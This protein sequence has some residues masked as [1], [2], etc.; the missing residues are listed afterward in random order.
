MYDVARRRW[1]QSWTIVHRAVCIAVLVLTARPLFAQDPPP[2]IGPFVIDFHGV[3]PKFGDDPQLAAS[4][5]LSQTELPGPTIGLSGAVHVY[6]P[7]FAGVTIGIGGEAIIAR[8]STSPEVTSASSPTDVPTATRRPVTETL[9]EISP[10]ISL[11]FGNGHGWSYLSAGIGRAMW[12][13]V[14]EG[15][16]PF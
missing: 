12:S 16:A 3:V 11:N 13:I 14:P 2:R 15:R 4:R 10:Q 5:A 8:S 7:K 9:K 1:S 6:L